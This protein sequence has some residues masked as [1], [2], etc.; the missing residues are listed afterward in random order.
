MNLTLKKSL[1]SASILTISAI[2]MISCSKKS[3]STATAVDNSNLIVNT[4]SSINSQVAKISGVV[5]ADL[6]TA[7]VAE[8]NIGIMAAPNFDTYWAT[9]ALFQNILTNSGMIT[10][11]QYM[12]YHLKASATRADGSYINVFGRMKNALAIFCAVGHASTTLGIPLDSSGYPVNGNHSITFTA[13]LKTTMQTTCGI[14]PNNIPDNTVMV[15]TVADA[16]GSYVK[17][18]TFSTFN[19]SYFVK[20]TS[21]EIN[22]VSAESQSSGAVSRTVLSWNKLTNV[23]RVEYVSAQGTASAS[24]AG[25]YVYRLY[26]DETNDIGLV[27]SAEGSAAQSTYESTRYI[28]A[29]KPNTGDAFSLSLILDYGSGNQLNGGAVTEA[30]VSSATGNILTDGSRCTESSTRLAGSSISGVAT[31]LSDFYALRTST[32]WGTATQ[33]TVLTWTNTTNMLTT[34]ITAN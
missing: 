5:D 14:S 33:D 27:L 11:K 8:Q 1:Y 32:A 19:Q 21:D 18:F 17:K 4:Y 30:C 29:G 2:F 24:Q 34:A 23:M 7:S 31:L 20:M 22:I 26:F 12:G 3:E 9:T 13:S 6:T 10:A 16:A 25:V 28:L 15:L